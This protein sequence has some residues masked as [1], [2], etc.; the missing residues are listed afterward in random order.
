MVIKYMSALVLFA[1]LSV[2][3]AADPV[4]TL[5]ADAEALRAPEAGADVSGTEF[6]GENGCDSSDVPK[7]SFMRRYPKPADQCSI[8]YRKCCY[9]YCPKWCYRRFIIKY[10]C[11]WI[12]K[13]KCG[14]YQKTE[15][16]QPWCRYFHY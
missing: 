14:E 3:F 8:E 4:S 5:P 6:D 11:G 2:A 13:R 10:Q 15:C 1:V 16:L 12:K 7:E 9:V